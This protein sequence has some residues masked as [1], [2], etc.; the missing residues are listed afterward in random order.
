[1]KSQPPHGLAHQTGQGAHHRVA[2]LA[3][4]LGL[5]DQGG[6]G[7][8]DQHVDGAGADQR[9]GNVQ[10]LLAGIGLGNEQTV[11]VNAKGSG[12][13][14]LQGVLHVDIRGHAVVPLGG[15]HD[16][17]GQG[18]LAGGLGTVDLHDPAPG[19]AADAQR[20]VQRQGAGGQGFHVHGDIVAK[21]HDGALA[22]ILLDLCNGGLQSLLLV[23]RG[24]HRD[25]RFFL[26]CHAVLSFFLVSE[27]SISKDMS[28]KPDFCYSR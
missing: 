2:D 5:R 6:H 20:Q 16:V 27:E 26:F 22:V 10:S 18:G 12:I 15:G 19:N 3:V 28:N 24:G 11:D 21:A 9:L 23:G 8:D 4:Q 14:G 7:V 1:M 25:R 17:Q 13:G